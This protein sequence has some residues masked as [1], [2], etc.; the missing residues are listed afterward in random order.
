MEL[1]GFHKLSVKKIRQTSPNAETADERAS[2]REEEASEVVDEPARTNLAC[3]GHCWKCRITGVWQCQILAVGW[4]TALLVLV[5]MLIFSTRPTAV[6]PSDAGSS[7][8][9]VGTVEESTSLIR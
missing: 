4:V 1:L 8:R 6:I 5:F 7:Y 9:G 2:E 3:P